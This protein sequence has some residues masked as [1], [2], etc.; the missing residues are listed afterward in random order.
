MEAVYSQ[1]D[2]AFADYRGKATGSAVAAG[3]AGALVG[4]VAPAAS[5]PSADDPGQGDGYSDYPL[6]MSRLRAAVGKLPYG[7]DALFPAVSAKFDAWVVTPENARGFQDWLKVQ[8]RRHVVAG[9]R[10]GRFAPTGF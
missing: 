8:V 9:T 5:D 4:L 6:L 2:Y 1:I 7:A 10:D 3:L